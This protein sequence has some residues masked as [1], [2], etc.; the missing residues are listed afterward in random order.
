MR[1]TGFILSMALVMVFLS[2]KDDPI[3]PNPTPAGPQAVRFVLNSLPADAPANNASFSAIV[4]VEDANNAEVVS[5]K[6]LAV[7]MVNGKYISE[8]IDLEI[9]TYKLTKYIL[10]N[11]DGLSRFASPR[12]NSEKAALVQKPLNQNIT[13]GN[14]NI[15]QV[16]EVVK[17]ETQDKAE[18]FGYPAGSFGALNSETF[19]RIKLQAVVSVGD[20]VYDSIPANFKITSWNAAGQKF[21]KDTLL[22]A[23]AKEVY[24]NAEHVRFSFQVSKWGITDEMTINREQLIEESTYVLGGAKLARKLRQEESFT[25]INGSYQPDAKAIYNY[26]AGD[27]LSNVEYYQKKPQSAE[28]QLVFKDVYS[29]S[30]NNVT[31]IDRFEGDGDKVGVTEFTYNPQGTKVTNIHQTSY[32]QQTGAAVEYGFP[33]GQAEIVIDYLYSNGHSMEYK[34]KIVRGNKVEDVAFTSRGGG[35]SGKYKYDFNINPYAHMNMPNIF[36][37]NLSRNNM[38][39]QT[40]TYSGSIPSAEPGN[41]QYTYDDD[42][43]PVQVIKSYKAYQSQEVLY[44]RKTVFTY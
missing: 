4:S 6:K 15:D 1:K 25:L 14:S 17:I 7:T 41:F 34:M 20:I 8:K 24:L 26:G 29:Y 5:N 43:Y 37:S 42:G 35:E 3:R 36:L 28:L 27:V 22:S 31:R 30:G 21:E 12:S 16:V 10:V 33:P 11:G 2:C 40:K 44:K 19:V 9:G 39:D 23:G 13:V 18:S 32:D 38:T